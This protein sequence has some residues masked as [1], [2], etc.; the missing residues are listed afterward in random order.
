M[1]TEQERCDGTAEKMMLLSVDKQSGADHGLGLFRQWFEYNVHIPFVVPR[2]PHTEGAAL[3]DNWTH[4]A[5]S[6]SDVEHEKGKGE[7]ST[8][9]VPPLAVR[10]G[11]LTLL[12]FLVFG[13]TLSYATVGAIYT[14]L[15]NDQG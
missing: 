4:H 11:T 1:A 13:P 8:V 3:W 6:P 7:D 9:P 15:K 2:I 5:G 12:F 10:I 14:Q